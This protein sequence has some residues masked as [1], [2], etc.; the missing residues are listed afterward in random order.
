M[1]RFLR[2]H[3]KVEQAF[4][5]V[6]RLVRQLA[7]GGVEEFDAVVLIAVVRSA[8][9]HAEAAV[10][11]LRHVRDARRR[12]GADQHHIDARGNESRL[13]GRLEHVPGHARVLADEH[14]SSA[15]GSQHSRGR[16]R[17][18]Q[19]KI[20]GHG[21]LTDSAAHAIGAEISIQL[22]IPCRTAL[23][24]PMVSY[25]AA[26]SWVRT[27]RA[28]RITARAA[29]PKPPY[30]RSST[31]LPRIRPMKLLRDKPTSK[32]APSAAKRDKI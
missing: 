30:N 21:R 26:T 7:A 9:D 11:A 29:S 31:A 12:Q 25:V 17:Q 20:H 27:M 23:T 1:L 2:H 16:A 24:M 10:Q 5:L 4:D 19:G 18:A 22:S 32:G 28:P 6:L 15:A 14:P 13:Q 3:G 8:D